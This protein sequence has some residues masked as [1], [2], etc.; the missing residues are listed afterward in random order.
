MWLKITIDKRC[1]D[2]R[3]IED[4]LDLETICIGWTSELKTEKLL[5][6]PSIFWFSSYEKKVELNLKE[7]ICVKIQNYIDKPAN[8]NHIANLKKISFT[9]L[10]LQSLYDFISSVDKCGSS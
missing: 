10:W 8:F 3:A 7:I 4:V 2:A 6:S 9:D 1:T 5:Q